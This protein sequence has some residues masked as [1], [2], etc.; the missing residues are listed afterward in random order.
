MA[1]YLELSAVINICIL[2]AV[3]SAVLCV[4]CN[5]DSFIANISYVHL[6]AVCDV[7]PK[8]VEEEDVGKLLLTLAVVIIS[9]QFLL[10]LLIPF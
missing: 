4:M 5:Q 6:S 7:T 1:D 9:S 2:H 10:F 3:L 8:E